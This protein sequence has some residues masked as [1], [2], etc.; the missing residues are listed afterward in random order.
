MQIYKEVRLEHRSPHPSF[1]RP[2]TA[3]AHSHTMRFFA[4]T[5]LLATAAAVLAMPAS[6]AVS[7]SATLSYDQTYDD[8]NG[9][10]TTVTCSD[11][12]NGMITLGKSDFHTLHP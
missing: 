2:E 3:T 6:E 11:G 7:G 1:T 10:L 5:Y 12:R 9:S 4:L 8:P